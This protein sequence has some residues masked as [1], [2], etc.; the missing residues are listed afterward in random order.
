MP[1]VHQAAVFVFPAAGQARIL[2]DRE[3]LR[4]ATVPRGKVMLTTGAPQEGS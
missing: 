4:A 3:A 2:G 1:G